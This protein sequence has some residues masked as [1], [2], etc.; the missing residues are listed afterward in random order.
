MTETA[1]LSDI[2]SFACVRA[3][4]TVNTTASSHLWS[5]GSRAALQV[6]SYNDLKHMETA[7]VVKLHNFCQL[8]IAQPC[9]KFVHPNRAARIDNTRSAAAASPFSSRLPLSHADCLSPALLYALLLRYQHLSFPVSSPATVHGLA[10]Y[11]EAKLYGDIAISIVPQTFSHGTPTVLRRPQCSKPL[12]LTCSFTAGL[13]P[14][15][16]H[17]QLVPHVH[18]AAPPGAGAAGRHGRRARVEERQRT[19][20][21]SLTGSY[22]PGGDFG[23]H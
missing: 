3:S 12:T 14:V 23:W 22:A 1:D 7:Y 10:G 16:R 9:F 11:F 8:G 17:V 2:L 18:P 4:D 5:R 6:R 19:E 20:G 13:S 21:A 15:N